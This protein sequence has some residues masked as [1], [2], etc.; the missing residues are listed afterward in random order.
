MTGRSAGGVACGA[1]AGGAWA[2]GVWAGGVWAG[3][4]GAGGDG[5]GGA[6][7]GGGVGTGVGVEGGFGLVFGCGFG[8]V[9]GR[10]VGLKETC[11][12]GCDAWWVAARPLVREPTS[13]RYEAS[14]IG[15]AA[16][17][18]TVR[19]LGAARR[20]ASGGVVARPRAAGA[21]CGAFAGAAVLG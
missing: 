20:W 2:G 8:F 9:T 4:V 14:T 17:D 5:V 11:L 3:G 6:G 12:R 13:V 7:A 1:W 18:L 21:G 19:C 16:R 10:E 15:L